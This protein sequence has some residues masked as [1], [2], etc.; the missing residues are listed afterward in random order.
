[1]K[2]SLGKSSL[3]GIAQFIISTLL[4]FIAIPIFV[5]IL[6]T[7]AYGIFSLVAIVGSVNTFANF[8]LNSSL[9][10]F[11][12]EQGKTKE[13]DHD[14]I[15]TFII[16]IVI[17]CPL[18][19][20]GILFHNSI[21]V[22]I[23]SVPI[24]LLGDARWLFFSMLIGNIFIL[25]G[26]VFT[27]ILDSQQKVYLT[28]FYQ[29]IYNIIYWS[30]ILIAISFGYSLKGVAMAMLIATIIWFSIVTISALRSWGKL[31]FRGLRN[32]A[33]RIIGK[34]L[35]YGL[36]IYTAGILGFFHEPIAKILVSHFIGVTE[37][38]FFDIGL[39]VKNQVVGLFNKLLT[40]LYP[41]I[42]KLTQTDNF[43]FLVHD[44][45][46]KIFLAVIPI[47]GIIILTA[48]PII[49]LIFYSQADII[50]ITVIYIV[51]AYLLGSTTVIPMYL[52]LMAKGH[53]SKIIIVQGLNAVVNAIFFFL[54]LPWLGYYAIV[55]ST[56]ASISS[57]FGLLISYQKRYLDSLIFDSKKQLAAV[58]VSFII[59]FSLGYYTTIII[60]SI[61]WKIITPSII[62]VLMT[63]ITYRYF[64]LL[65]HA[66]INR[67]FGENTALSKLSVRI[68][69]K[70]YR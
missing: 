39:R 63:I 18:T 19:L 5:R 3:T 34:Q 22:H 23:L 41:A 37:V 25:L 11:L 52:F 70:Y 7:E 47:T 28:N 20:G 55:V 21:L 27:A 32:D 6:G 54:F 49:N 2:G 10:R 62:V 31:S 26:Q 56:V 61:M 43:K 50:S 60:E 65:N 68:L 58:I 24:Q 38:G 9:V 8:G 13:S 48:D 53:P 59:A 33:M 45:E 14:I 29:M 69:C 16:S 51:S 30:T 40:P 66:D 15:I 44:I 12:A 46:Q 57:S 4:V 35:S 17:L 36:K 42:S 64:A 67:Y 1:M